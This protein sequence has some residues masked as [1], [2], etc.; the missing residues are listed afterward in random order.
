M[1]TNAYDIQTH[2][3]V[4]VLIVQYLM[5]VLEQGHETGGLVQVHYAQ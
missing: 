5:Q 1:Y 2:L 4:A 3:F